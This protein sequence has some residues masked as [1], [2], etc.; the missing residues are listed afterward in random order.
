VIEPKPAGWGA[1]YAAVFGDDDVVAVYHLR[2]PYPEETIAKLEELAASG[3]VLDAGC[4][5]GELARRLA[6]LVERVDAVDVSAPMLA[7]ARALPGAHATNLRWVHGSIEDA[8]LEPP[9]ALAVAGD[10]VHWFD[11]PSAMPRIR[12]ALGDEGVLAIVHRDWLRDEPARERLRP[13]YARHSWNAD[14]APLDPIEELERRGL[15]VKAGEHVSDPTPWRPTL[16]EIVGGH[17]SMSG[18]ARSRLENP[19]AFAREVREALVATLTPTRDRY[20][21]DVVGTVVWGAP[22][23]ETGA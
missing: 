22:C 19:D 9:Y 21:L 11:W 4:G 3:A 12:E 14:F 16:D 15:F 6:P 13:I 20:E 23:A 5:T 7:E 17:F 1:T 8:R 18:F 10:S 2:P